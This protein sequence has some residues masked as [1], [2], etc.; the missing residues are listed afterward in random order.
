[1]P[2]EKITV[3]AV[4][5]V[6]QDNVWEFYTN[7]NHIT[8]WNFA[9]PS[10]HCP[11]ASNDLRVGGKYSARMEARD[12][13]AGFDFEAIYEEIT[14]GRF[15]RYGMSGREVTVHF[16]P[17]PEGTEI[18]VSFDPENENPI[19]LQRQG[20]QAILDN[21]KNYAIQMANS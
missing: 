7:P 20:W 10:W 5:P 13:S 4:L 14:I 12:G 2:I 1:M 18:I 3:H 19:D 8:Q 15:F 11:S 16:K 21:F 17:H 6:D 9:H